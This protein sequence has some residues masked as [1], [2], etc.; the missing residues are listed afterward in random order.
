MRLRTLL[1]VDN[2]VHFHLTMTGNHALTTNISA[3]V[4]GSVS[5]EFDATIPVPIPIAP[6]LVFNLSSG[7]FVEVSGSFSGEYSPTHYFN[8][9]L[10]YE[11]DQGSPSNIP[12]HIKF[13]PKGQDEPT[14]DLMGNVSF[15]FGVFAE[16]GIAI[17]S[18]ETA[19]VGVALEDGVS[20]DV[21]MDLGGWPY[22]LHPILLCMKNIKT[23]IC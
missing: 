2:G 10:H 21:R 1:R 13:I 22:H 5:P 9:A 19:K 15:K 23:M 14:G 11:Y 7:P 4:E 16:M 17:A 20:I 12:A 18:K 8:T 6:S 3:S